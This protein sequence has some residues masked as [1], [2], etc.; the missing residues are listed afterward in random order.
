ML[1]L[2]NI[3]TTPQKCS[4]IVLRSLGGR[5]SSG[6]SASSLF[7]V[8][9]SH[10]VLGRNGDMAFTK[11]R[12]DEVFPDGVIRDARQARCLLSGFFISCSEE[13]EIWLLL[14]Q[15][16]MRSCIGLFSVR[17]GFISALFGLIRSNV[18]FSQ[19]LCRGDL[20]SP[21][22]CRQY[23][24]P[25]YITQMIILLIILLSQKNNAKHAIKHKC[26][27]L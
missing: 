26:L 2:K 24:I 16:L 13:T 6:R 27:E 8:G 18:D 5:H 17:Q 1:K 11:T 12:F 22:L 4:I 10:F 15:G 3:L 21:V 19:S 20:W 25:H 14:K 23:I 9:V 7:A